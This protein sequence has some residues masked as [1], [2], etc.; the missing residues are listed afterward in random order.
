ML[1][2]TFWSGAV[3]HLTAATAPLVE[4]RLRDLARREFVRRSRRSSIV[5]E[6]EYAVSHAL[7][8][9]VAYDE[10]PRAD[11][12]RFHELAGHWLA[13]PVGDAARSGDAALVAHHFSE[14]LRW[15]PADTDEHARARVRALAATW[16]ARAAQQAIS[17]DP[18]AAL[19]HAETS[20]VLTADD[21]PE[22]ARRLLVRGGAQSKLGREEAALA[23]Y[24]AAQ[25]AAEGHGQPLVAGLAQTRASGEL[26]GLFRTAEATAAASAA[27]AA[28]EGLPPGPEL[29]EA[30]LN[31]AVD[32]GSAGLPHEAARLTEKAV[33]LMAVLP[34]LPGELEVRALQQR[35]HRALWAGDP[36]ARQYLTAGLTL[37]EKLQLSG[38]L[39]TLHDELA[40][41]E[42]FTTSVT[43][44][45]PYSE[46][47]IV[48]AERTGMWATYLV[49]VGNHVEGLLMA[50]RVAEAL[51][52]CE[53]ANTRESAVDE[54]ES[55]VAF[56]V[57][58]A[59][60]LHVGGDSTGARSLSSA[61]YDLAR[62]RDARVPVRS[63]ALHPGVPPSRGAA[64]P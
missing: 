29:V 53:E 16:H 64:P 26:R 54:G 19:E 60:A 49:I 37:A 56:Q 18:A 38:P 31:L 41:L 58:R 27:V 42:Y 13:E 59:W 51:R 57:Y 36:S 43:A 3:G 24:T 5:G 17:H 61:M 6:P 30:Y 11:R 35:G 39:S 4:G 48:L 33:E 8:A 22:R 63:R 50:G 28:L 44:S 9:D 1:G 52:W 2:H 15:T 45:L 55:R 21:D 34:D 23:T 40:T 25:A 62:R 46:A 12:A 7:V 10:L 32:G 20:L 14:A 47:A